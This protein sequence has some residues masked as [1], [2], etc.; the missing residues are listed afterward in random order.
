MSW[1]LLM[2]YQHWECTS[3][4]GQWS[5]NTLRV[6][7]LMF[8]KCWPIH[9]SK[10]MSWSYQSHDMLRVY[11]LK[12]IMKY[13]HMKSIWVKV[14][15]EVPTCCGLTPFQLNT[16]MRPISNDHEILWT[17]TLLGW[18]KSK[19]WSFLASVFFETLHFEIWP[20][21]FPQL[22]FTFC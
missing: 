15:Y 9:H 6:Y 12:L 16:A 11:E 14:V 3:W 8:M 18:C 13:Q 2:K 10:Y 17:V 19:I 5:T 22:R 21:S 1:S 20:H 4:S 7:E